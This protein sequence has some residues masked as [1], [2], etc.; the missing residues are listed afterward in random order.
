MKKSLL[1]LIQYYVKK[2]V[3]LQILTNAKEDIPDMKRRDKKKLRTYLIAMGLFSEITGEELNE[4]FIILTKLKTKKILFKIIDYRRMM[5][6]DEEIGTIKDHLEIITREIYNP[7]FKKKYKKVYFF[8]LK[9]TLDS[10]LTKKAEKKDENEITSF[11]LSIIT[12][13]KIKEDKKIIEKAKRILEKLGHKDIVDEFNKINKNFLK[14]AEEAK[15]KL[16]K[17]F[18]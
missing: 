3:D 8:W 10:L 7:F 6:Y 12:N 4:V 14:K 13:R 5:G 18:K 15:A 2:G 16:S 17:K 11:I 1:E 9:T